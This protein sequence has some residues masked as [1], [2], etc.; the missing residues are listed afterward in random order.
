MIIGVSST[1]TSA[2]HHWGEEGK[3]YH[4]E[5]C[6]TTDAQDDLV[7]DPL[8]RARR[9]RPCGD[10]AAAH[11]RQDGAREG[12]GKV[13]AEAGDGG[14][15]QE[16]GE[17]L[18]DD[19]GQQA[20][21]AHK[22]RVALD[23]L[24]VDG[25][26]AR[27]DE[28]DAG[29]AR[30]GQAGRDDDLVAEQAE[31]DEGVVAAGASPFPHDEQGAGRHGSDEQADDDRRAPRVVVAAQVEGEEQHDDGGGQDGGAHQVELA[32]EAGRGEERGQR[33][34]GAL[35]RDVDEG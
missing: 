22:G 5:T 10:E 21:A 28:G 17:Q 15:A 16:G 34:L 3:P 24:E 18:A 29:Q 7:R 1:F 33:R 11:G 30:V 20:D 32:G 23:A 19:A 12:P 25:D 9:G 6:T 31:G 4:L 27:R 8:G 14:A 13:V 35:F 26:E 2:V